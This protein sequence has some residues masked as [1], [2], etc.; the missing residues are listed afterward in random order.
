LRPPT[1]GVTGDGAGA[2]LVRPLLDVER[3]AI[4]RF[5]ARHRLRYVDDPSN[6][7]PAYARNL[8]RA[9]VLPQLAR[10][11]PGYLAAAARSIDLVADL[12]Q[13]AL[14]V[15]HAD[16]AA[17]RDAA[18]TL[19][20]D[21]LRALSLPRRAAVM[22]AWLAQAGI[23][24]PSRARLGEALRQ[25]VEPRK[26]GNDAAPRRFALGGRE[27]RRDGNRLS[28]GASRIAAPVPAS[29]SENLN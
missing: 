9:T 15:A 29:L 18:G 5:A 26:A 27:I 17:S 10:I 7:A 24:A 3:S 4:E 21:R 20:L 12:A 28:I 6:H 16:L 19:Q 25:L 23:E 11:R 14:E 13:L 1:R 8:L 2:L 22:R